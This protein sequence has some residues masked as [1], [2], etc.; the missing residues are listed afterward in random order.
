MARPN[1]IWFRKDTGW[2]MVTLGGKKVRLVE[3]KENKK[4]AEQKFHELA[5]L[6][7]R[8]PE[9]PSARVADVIEAFLAWAKR[10]R[11]EETIR[12]YVW[13]GQSF[14]EHSGYLLSSALKP[15][16][17]TRWI[18]T[19]GWGPTTE[20][21]ARRSVYRAFSWACEEGI[22]AV[23]PLKGMKCPKARTRQRIMTRQEYAALMKYGRREFKLFLFALRQTGCRPKEARLLKWSQ[24]TDDRWVL[25]KHK[26]ADAVGK[27]RIIY[28]TKPMRRL[29]ENLRRKTG[30][31][32]VFVNSQGK[33]WTTN[34][35][36]LRIQRIKDKTPLADD[37]TAY[38]L[39]HAFGTNAIMNGVDVATV[40]ELMGHSSLEMISKVYCH[41][42]GEHRHLQEAV[43]RVSRPLAHAKPQPNGKH[44]DAG[45]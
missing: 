41:L 32:Y 20:R 43:E 17:V 21:N 10:H 11:S 45:T 26:T 42:A 27:S 19:H 22:L 4:L 13:H 8:V 23:N 31:E 36:K 9:T 7:A 33:P 44:P 16:H 40:A 25:D 29:M 28:L 1:R 5:V 37:V 12:N 14:S 30:S 15:I 39:R 24:V 35:I 34:A 3:G 6:Q 18:D 2:W 38:L